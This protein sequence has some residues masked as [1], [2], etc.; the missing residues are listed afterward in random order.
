M[1][2]V[3][4]Q[5]D[6]CTGHANFPPRASTGGSP[7]VYVNGIPLHRQGDP[8]A[9]HCNRNSCHDGVL[10][11]GSSTV[12]ANGQAVGRIGDPVSCGSAVAAGSANVF[13]GG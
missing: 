7:N 6:G 11:S 9:V 2:A 4:R 8:W 5:G 1:P 10:G 3:T 13:A 12:F